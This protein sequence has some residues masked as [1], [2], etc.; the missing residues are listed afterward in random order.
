MQSAKPPH[1]ALNIGVSFVHADVSHCLQDN[2]PPSITG[3]PILTGQT[4]AY[5]TAANVDQQV[6]VSEAE[7]KLFPACTF[8]VITSLPR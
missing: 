5:T 4:T 3:L 7:S 6:A 8:H 1:G 2:Y